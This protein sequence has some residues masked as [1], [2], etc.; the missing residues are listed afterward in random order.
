MQTADSRI[1]TSERII[2]LPPVPRLSGFS[3]VSAPPSVSICRVSRR[4]PNSY[5]LPFSRWPPIE[6][7]FQPTSRV[8]A[9]TTR[10]LPR[11]HPAMVLDRPLRPV[12]PFLSP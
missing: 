8:E 4:L 2:E 10:P 11:Q 9:R 7:P 12:D 5:N 1:K 6:V 3:P